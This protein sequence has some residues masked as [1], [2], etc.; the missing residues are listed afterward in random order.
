MRVVW[1]ETQNQH[2]AGDF[3]QRGHFIKSPETGQRAVAILQELLW[4]GHPITAPDDWG[5]LPILSVHDE[6]YVKFLKESADD[7]AFPPFP[8]VHP[9]GEF[10]QRPNSVVGLIGWHTGDMA[11]NIN[12]GTWPAAYAAAQVA[13]SA[14]HFVVSGEHLAYALCRPPGHHAGAQR[15]MGFCYLNNAAIAAQ[16]LR[17]RFERVAILDIDVHHGNGTQEIFYERGDVFFASIHGDPEWFYPYYW[18]YANQTGSGEGAGANLNVP[19]PFGAGD[20]PYLACLNKALEGISEYGPDALVLS[21]G[22]D[23]YVDDPHGM[24]AVGRDAFMTAAR[25]ISK[26]AIPTVIVQEGGYP[27]DGLGVL[28]ADFLET[29]AGG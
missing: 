2:E 16:V 15:A 17:Q 4:R 13:T 11:C 28:V 8:N 29:F 25:R 19:F 6:A 9:R 27:F 1:S 18:G 10:A 23:A 22:S 5:S 20:E 21:F 12:S 14:A 24:H 26:L 3:M 7:P